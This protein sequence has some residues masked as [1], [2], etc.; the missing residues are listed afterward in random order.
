MDLLLKCRALRARLCTYR[1]RC[2]EAQVQHNDHHYDPP[3]NLR[4]V[5]VKDRLADLTF[6]HN[7]C[8]SQEVWWQLHYPDIV[9]TVKLERRH[10][11]GTAPPLQVP[12]SRPKAPEETPKQPIAKAEKAS[13]VISTIRAPE[14]PRPQARPVVP[15]MPQ[16]SMPMAARPNRG[17]MSPK[18]LALALY[19]SFNFVVKSLIRSLNP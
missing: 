7:G 11:L 12:G 2:P 8:L 19:L 15:A 14:T 5:P 9:A 10:D 17:A 4:S 13:Q 3:F 1:N 18:G 6:H 16:T